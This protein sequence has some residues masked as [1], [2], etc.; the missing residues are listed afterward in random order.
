LTIVFNLSPKIEKVKVHIKSMLKTKT[1]NI[2][3]SEVQRNLFMPMHHTAWPP[4]ATVEMN[5]S[6]AQAGPAD[7]KTKV[8]P[9]HVMRRISC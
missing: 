1:N 2:K 6:S 4:G 5:H 7:D 3:Q 8:V 9:H